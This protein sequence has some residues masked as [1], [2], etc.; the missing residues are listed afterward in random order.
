[1]CVA[2]AWTTIS[3][4][5]PGA[6]LG[7]S[8]IKVLLKIFCAI[9]IEVQ[10]HRNGNKGNW[11]THSGTNTSKN[12]VANPC[13]STRLDFKGIDQTRAHCEYDTADPG[14]WYID[15]EN[16]NQAS[17]SY[18]SNVHADR[19][20]DCSDAGFLS[21]CPFDGL[22]VERQA[23][24]LLVEKEVG[25]NFSEIHRELFDKISDGDK[26]WSFLEYLEGREL[27]DFLAWV[28]RIGLLLR[29]ETQRESEMWRIGRS[30][31]MILD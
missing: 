22:K 16:G 8:L 25:S 15:A 26:R 23:K 13:A 30:G 24:L 17:H 9:E 2:P 6:C 29:T 19:I 31:A 11:H 21:A 28:Q 18:R 7:I 4:F 27:N 20:R 12:L 5:T 14:E 10:N 3:G 1:M